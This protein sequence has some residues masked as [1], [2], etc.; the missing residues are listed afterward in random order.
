MKQAKEVEQVRARRKLSYRDA[1][2]YVRSAND[3][4]HSNYQTTQRAQTSIPAKTPF[5]QSPDQRTTLQIRGIPSSQP[6][7]CKT[8]VQKVEVGTQTINN[9]V[10]NTQTPTSLQEDEISQ[11]VVLVLRI[12]LKMQKPSGKIVW[13]PENLRILVNS[14]L[15]LRNE[16]T[17]DPLTRKEEGSLSLAQSSDT[18]DLEQESSEPIKRKNLKSKIKLPGLALKSGN[19]LSQESERITRS[20][21]LEGNRMNPGEVRGE[22]QAGRALEGV[23]PPPNFMGF[24]AKGIKGR[25]RVA[26]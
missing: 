20:V 9:V 18:L 3:Q 13:E 17:V 12:I 6:S 16:E 23:K 10:A 15:E 26:K 5:Q 19:P 7:T 4:P 2:Q 14:A 11:I 25:Q 1:L 21:G 22:D 8:S 24:G